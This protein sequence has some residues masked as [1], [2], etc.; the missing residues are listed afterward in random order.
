MKLSDEQTIADEWLPTFENVSREFITETLYKILFSNKL[1]NFRF[2]FREE[3]AIQFIE[4]VL[5]KYV[6]NYAWRKEESYKILEKIRQ[7]SNGNSEEPVMVV[8][9]YKLFFEYLRQIYEKDIELFFQRTE[10]TSFCRYEKDNLFEQIWLRLTPNDFNNAEEFLRK[11]AQMIKDRTLKKYDQ[12]T[13]LGSMQCLNN[14]IVCIK[15]GIARTW[16]ENFRE[17][18]IK[19]YDKE[20][21][22]DK[23]CFYRPY[24]KLPVIRY[25]IYQKNGKK[26]CRI[27]SIQDKNI[28]RE[29]N[30]EEN[31]L[32]KR[33]DRQKYRVNKDISE[34][35]ISKV[36]PKNV[37]ALS[38][39]INLI[40][41][42]GITDI[43]VPSMYSLDH[44]Y[45]RKRNKTMLEQFKNSWPKE[46]RKK[47]QISYQREYKLF[48]RGF[49]KEDLISEIKTERL[50]LTFR[51]IL[52]HYPKGN[53]TA[54]PEEVDNYMHIQIP[55]V[56]DASE[57]KGDILKEFYNLV[58]TLD[59]E[60]RNDIDQQEVPTLTHDNEI[61]SQL[62]E[63]TFSL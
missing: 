18:Q 59:I 12:E 7:G 43:E 57:I 37:I 26:I 33:I 60:K 58:Q 15:N 44:E 56:K 35:D 21:Y 42:E 61:D 4:N 53:V 62:L 48:L 27:G 63:E 10:M 34:E 39:F 8:S 13:Y 40:Q 46:R 49:R 25:G 6:D 47:Q 29:E 50:L 38:I 31:N 9:D 41:R 36:E 24:Y 54:Y 1:P 14:H 20:Y 23:E 5:R 28:Y 55:I 17:I 2:Y 19:I 3:E 51:R 45:H 32:R 11:Q 16:D 30:E 52:N 22:N